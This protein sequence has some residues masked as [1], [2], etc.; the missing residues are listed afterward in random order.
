M[1]IAIYLCLLHVNQFFFLIHLKLFYHFK[2]KNAFHSATFSMCLLVS[3]F[4]DAF[5]RMCIPFCDALQSYAILIQHFYIS[6][7]QYS[8]LNGCIIIII[9]IVY[10]CLL[11]CNL[12]VQCPNHKSILLNGQNKTKLFLKRMHFAHM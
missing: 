3:I 6:K 1:E 4:F 7:M 12:V 2:Q 5:Y 9:L 10:L 8:M 11:L